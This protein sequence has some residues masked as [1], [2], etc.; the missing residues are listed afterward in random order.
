MAVRTSSRW[1]PIMLIT[2]IME[3][4]TATIG[5]ALL[6]MLPKIPVSGPNAVPIRFAAAGSR[7]VRLAMFPPTALIRSRPPLPMVPVTRFPAAPLMAPMPL[8]MAPPMPPVIFPAMFCALPMAP[9]PIC[10]MLLIFCCSACAGALSLIAWIPVCSCPPM[11][12]VTRCTRPSSLP[13]FPRFSP[14]KDSF[15]LAM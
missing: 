5:R 7:L 8:P 15:T 6:S 3:L 12:F 13:R 14:A 2:A 11:C 9:A 10:T 1:S 4:T